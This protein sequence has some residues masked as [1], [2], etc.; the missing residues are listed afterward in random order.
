MF[1]PIR[2][3]P[4]IPSCIS[5]PPSA[6]SVAPDERVGGRVMGEPWFGIGLELAGDARRE[7]LAELDAP[8]VERVDVPDRSLHQDAVLV[9]R[10]ELAERFGLKPVGENRV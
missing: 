9:Q 6:V 3:S 1:A 4:I 2:P 8:L 10:D 7:H 5:L